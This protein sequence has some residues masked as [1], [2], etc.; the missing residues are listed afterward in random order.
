M[1]RK[2]TVLTVF[3]K[4]LEKSNWPHIYGHFSWSMATTMYN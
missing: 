3:P 2:R 1:D 4:Q